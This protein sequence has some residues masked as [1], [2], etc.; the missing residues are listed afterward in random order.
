MKILLHFLAITFFVSF[1]FVLYCEEQPHILDRDNQ[2]AQR[3]ARQYEHLSKKVF[4]KKTHFTSVLQEIDDFEKIINKNNW[5][6][7][8]IMLTVLS[9]LDN[10]KHI[11]TEEVNV[12]NR[13]IERIAEKIVNL[14]TLN[15]QEKVNQ[16]SAF[17]FLRIKK[18][19]TLD[20]CIPA[21][22]KSRVS[23]LLDIRQSVEELYDS[24]WN[25]DDQENQLF[26]GD[27]VPPATYPYPF[28]SG[29]DFSNAE[30]EATRIAYK[31]Y[32][33]AKSKQAE[34]NNTQI[35]VRVFQGS[36][37][38]FT[39]EYLVDAYSTLPYHSSELR[40]LLEN[41]KIDKKVSE[42]I[43]RQVRENESKFPD[44]GTRL[45][46]SK[47]G[48]FKVRGK[49]ISQEGDLINLERTDGHIISFPL[50]E[51]REFDLLYIKNIGKSEKEDP[52]MTEF[53]NWETINGLFKTKAKF[54]SS[55]G[56]TVTIEQENGKQVTLNLEDLRWLDKN[57]VKEKTKQLN[58]GAEP[59]PAIEKMMNKKLS[60]E[61][62]N[63]H[64]KASSSLLN[65]PEPIVM[66]TWTSRDGQFSVQA[67]YI[68]ANETTV[69]IE[70][71]NGTRT[72]VEI[73]KLS[74][75]DQKYIERQRDAKKTKPVSV[76]H[77]SL[78]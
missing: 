52:P 33:L 8:S 61:E 60:P 57:V 63:E 44:N 71:E 23:R 39:N 42:E 10:R 38:D 35:I 78:R 13:E 45:W 19:N 1:G 64:I 4:D 75:P 58:Q 2:D 56:K 49:F 37:L 30:D 62:R 70:K 12:I 24:S 54:I 36:T 76:Y 43:L 74:E 15:L 3:L 7:I 48:L 40:S 73:S 14:E 26:S 28:A 9:L 20:D 6:Y 66:R 41:K 77:W 16:A 67:K 47:D 5:N 51:L 68:S 29:Q 50:M 32:L 53:R 17:R 46:M 25:P 31:N 22:R 34:K 65:Q 18:D 11:I 21:I 55:D 27:F 69:T 59:A 72:T